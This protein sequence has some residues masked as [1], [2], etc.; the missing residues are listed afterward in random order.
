MT[1]QEKTITATIVVTITGLGPNRES[2][3]PPIQAPATPPA[4]PT[5]PNRPISNIPQ[6]ST[7]AA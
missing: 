4:R 2:A 7:P 6:P 1:M 3:R 5:A